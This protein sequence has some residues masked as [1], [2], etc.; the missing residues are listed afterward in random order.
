MMHAS[1]ICRLAFTVIAI[2]APPP[3]PGSTSLAYRQG[4]DQVTRVLTTMQVGSGLLKLLQDP[5]NAARRDFARMRLSKLQ[6]TLWQDVAVLI[7]TEGKVLVSAQGGE[8][9]GEPFEVSGITRATLDT[10]MRY[11]RT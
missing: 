5:A 10:G 7:D 8:M 9:E 11:V 1:T 4:T 3:Q 2:S 6:E